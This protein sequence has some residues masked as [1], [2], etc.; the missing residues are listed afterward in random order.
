MSYRIITKLS[1]FDS[2]RNWDDDSY[3]K[4]LFDEQLA[5]LL[6]KGFDF[7]GTYLVKFDTK[8]YYVMTISDAVEAL[9]LKEGA[10]LVEF[11]SGNYGFVGYYGNYPTSKNCFE[12]LCSGSEI[13]AEY[14]HL[15]DEDEDE[16]IWLD[17][18]IDE[19]NA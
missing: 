5:V 3:S 6:S 16:D 2:S 15:A 4:K 1:T 19:L 17:K 13:I 12:I 7:Y 9:A 8:K 10:D 14:G 11:E 18:I